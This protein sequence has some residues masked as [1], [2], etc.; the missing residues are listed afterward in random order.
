MQSF[1]FVLLFSPSLCDIY[2]LS[3]PKG[4]VVYGKV[5][6]VVTGKEDP[7]DCVS[8]WDE[9]NSLPKT[10]VYNSR[11]KTCTAMTSAFG[12]KEGSSEEEAF[13]I[14]ESTQNLCPTN[15]TEAL[16]K[17]LGSSTAVALVYVACSVTCRKGWKRL[18]L[19]S[20]VNCYQIL[21]DFKKYSTGRDNQIYACEKK[22]SFAKATSIHSKQ[23]EQ[24]IS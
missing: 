6:D 17:V 5:G 8:H 7:R 10:F 11:S 2:L 4:T 15:A 14:Q 12:T 20:A 18:E 23:E 22:F 16:Q 19:P 24:F 13:L 3:L 1:V 9:S 21:T